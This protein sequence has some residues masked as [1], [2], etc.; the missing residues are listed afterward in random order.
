MFGS[1]NG[2]SSVPL[3]YAALR[4]AIEKKM[5][6]KTGPINY[7][8]IVFLYQR[9]V[10]ARMVGENVALQLHRTDIITYHPDGTKTLDDGGWMHSQMTRL[11]F[12]NAGIHIDMFK[13][14][15]WTPPQ[16]ALARRDD[17][18]LQM[19]LFYRYMHVDADNKP[20]EPSPLRVY[21]PN[22]EAKALRK[23]L[24]ALAKVYRE[25]AMLHAGSPQEFFNRPNYGSIVEAANDPKHEFDL[26]MYTMLQHHGN[27]W[28]LQ[29]MAP[30]K[31]VLRTLAM[32]Y[33]SHV[34]KM[35][36][37]DEAPYPMC[38]NNQGE[39]Q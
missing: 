29:Q 39:Q 30:Y 10:T 14:N 21:K 22:A 13:I 15:S 24:T 2:R 32:V 16:P 18:G 20:L 1:S 17:G 26:D 33:E 8:S 23:R 36:L 12:G 27:R 6:S 3:N 31:R 38:P 5:V 19:S 25:F 9:Y 34:E 28:D 4:H 35:H 7:R 37:L 11:W